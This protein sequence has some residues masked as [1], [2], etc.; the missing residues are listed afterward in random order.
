MPKIMH[1]LKVA[2]NLKPLEIT[3]T[4]RWLVMLIAFSHSSVASLTNSFKS[5]PSLAKP[6]YP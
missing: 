1:I 2:I 6:P 4:L 3:I 5:R